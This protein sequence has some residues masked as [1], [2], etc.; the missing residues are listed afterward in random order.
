MPGHKRVDLVSARERVG[1]IDAQFV[2]EMLGWSALSDATE[3][4]HDGGTTIA[5]LPPDRGGE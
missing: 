1:A 3:D 4:L 5:G 2:G